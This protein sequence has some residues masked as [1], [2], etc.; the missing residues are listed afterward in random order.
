MILAGDGEEAL[1]VYRDQRDQ[2]DL[3]ISDMVMPRSGGAEFYRALR[4]EGEKVPFLLVSGYTGAEATER[5]ILDPEV[6]I[7]P[8]PWDI[9]DLLKQVRKVLDED[10]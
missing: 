10:V 8:K 6:P 9:G 5:R 3:I 4:D 1:D 7:L 2:I